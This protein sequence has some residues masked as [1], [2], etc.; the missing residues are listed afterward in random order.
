MPDN[1]FSIAFKALQN[2]ADYA[3][4]PTGE[5]YRGFFAPGA[6]RDPEDIREELAAMHRQHPKVVTLESLETR[7]LEGRAIPLI[8][9]RHP[10]LPTG[11]PRVLLAAQLHAREFIGGETAMEALWDMLQGRDERAAA[12]LRRAE[13]DV[14]PL[15]NPDGVWRNV[16]RIRQRGWRF[17]PLHRGNARSVDL[18]RNFGAG[19][20]NRQRTYRWRLSDEFAGA[21]PFSEP[22]SQALRALVQARRYQAV[23]NLH[24]YS[25]VFLYPGYGD[26][27]VDPV[28]AEIARTLPALQPHEPYE[29]VHG[30]RFFART[31][32]ATA[33]LTAVRGT[34]WVHGTFD[35]WLFNEGIHT[36]LIEISKP[37]PLPEHAAEMV[38]SHLRLFN[39]PPAERLKAVQNVLPAIFAFYLGVL[40]QKRL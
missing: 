21:G 30:A 37:G 22:E 35:D 12:L 11:A 24:S 33:V 20:S 18:N 19:Y 8:R 15:I 2:A 38:L 28:V 17:G 31:A 23:I 4:G 9:L 16:R 6:Y 7:T 3:V 27:G 10:S 36:L 25:S 34:R 40:D 32:L 29:V 13:V 1:P 14:L 5:A 26:N 39:P